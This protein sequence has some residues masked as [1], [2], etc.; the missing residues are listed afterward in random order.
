[1]INFTF[2][3]G[4]KAQFF[5]LPK[6]KKSITVPFKMVRNM[7]IIKT[8]INGKGPYNFVMDTGVGLIVITD[9]AIGDSVGLSKRHVKV[10][11]LGN[12]TEYSATVTSGLNFNINGIVGENLSAAVLQKDRFGLSNYA[13]MPI[14]GLL[15]YDFF[16]SL[17]VKF[18]FWDS[19][20]IVARTGAIKALRKGFKLPIIIDQNKPYATA[21]VQY[22]EYPETDAKL[23]V[24]FGAGHSLLLD[25]YIRN[26]T[27]PQK[28]IKANLGVG[29]TGPLEGLLSRVA[30]LKIGKYE[31]KNVITSFPIVDT[32]ANRRSIDRDGNLGLGIL[33]RFTLIVDYQG[34]FIDLK[35]AKDF[36]A[37]FE[38]DMSGLEYYGDGDDY[39]TIII[40]RVEPGS[41][42]DDIGLK[43]DDAIAAINFKSVADLSIEQIDSYFKSG[44]DR[45]LLLDVYRNGKRGKF[46]LT[47][48]KRI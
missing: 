43:K 38:H 3:T 28:Y 34:G 45:S 13:G 17:A 21:K 29:L 11:G 12:S 25:N 6:N 40:S 18:S 31:F 19:T 5:E 9:P 33:K 35:P 44:D 26:N 46:I 4:L 24:D 47:L 37:A 41:A 20:M 10:S 39:K 8:M 23:V 7:V 2:T 30:M 36:K 48:K 27:L 14:H 15:G 16:N 1:M 32:A 22:A 42:A